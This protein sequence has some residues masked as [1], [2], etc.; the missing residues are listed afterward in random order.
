[1]VLQQV[2]FWLVLFSLSVY[3]QTSVSKNSLVKRDEQELIR[4]TKEISRASVEKD[5]ATLE[6]L[7]DDDFI[8]LSVSNKSF[9]KA[10]LIKL[11][12]AKNDDKNVSESSVPSEIQV[13]LYGKTAIII[14]TITDTERDQNGETVIQTKAFDVW[15]KTRKGWCWIA[16]RETLL[17]TD[18]K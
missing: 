2:C 13:F 12:T 5:A 9:R 14:S 10:E 4:L 1:M 7:I 18:K 3:P 15:K 6:R 16:S 8:L 11:W 17:P